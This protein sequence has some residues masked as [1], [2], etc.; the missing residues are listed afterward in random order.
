MKR[1]ETTHRQS[2]LEECHDAAL[3]LHYGVNGATVPTRM[4]LECT[5]V[6]CA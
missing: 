6:L 2:Q 3:L 4:P 5:A 1:S